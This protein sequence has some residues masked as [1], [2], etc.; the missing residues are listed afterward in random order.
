MPVHLFLL[1]K[2][3]ATLLLPGLKSKLRSRINL[4]CSLETSP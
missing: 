2:R 3:Q 4:M 1:D